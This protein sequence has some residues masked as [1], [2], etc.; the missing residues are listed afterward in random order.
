MVKLGKYGA[1]KAKSHK[2]LNFKQ[3]IKKN[4][5]KFVLVLEKQKYLCYNIYNYY[6]YARFIVILLRVFDGEI[7]EGEFE[8]QRNLSVC[9][10]PMRV[11]GI[12]TLNEIIFP[13]FPRMCVASL[14]SM[15]Y[16]P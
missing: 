15:R 11:L 13:T 7:D 12:F 14:V 6:T 10:I 2:T 16:S 9:Y 5:R 1:N 4:K 8:W 3:N